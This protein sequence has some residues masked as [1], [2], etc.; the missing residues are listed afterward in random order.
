MQIAAC[1]RQTESNWQSNE[2]ILCVVF[3]FF[4]SRLTVFIHSVAMFCS[5]LSNKCDFYIYPCYWLVRFKALHRKWF[6]CDWLQ[7]FFLSMLLFCHRSIV[8]KMRSVFFQLP[9]VR[10]KHVLDDTFAGNENKKPDEGK[11]IDLCCLMESVVFDV[12]WKKSTCHTWMMMFGKQLK[13]KT[14]GKIGKCGRRRKIFG[15]HWWVLRVNIARVYV[16]ATIKKS[17]VY[18]EDANTQR[19]KE[20]TEQSPIEKQNEKKKI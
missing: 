17:F 3:I 20:C 11:R 8:E 6:G 2:I 15:W 12:K 9:P 16:C 14:I 18:A 1:N 4:L 7:F 13:G 5:V 19:L 10:V